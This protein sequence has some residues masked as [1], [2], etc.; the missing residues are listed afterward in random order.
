[1][2]YTLNT[3]A[4]KCT[5]FLFKNLYR[6]FSKRRL[7]Q[8]D[9]CKH[10]KSNVF[11]L[12]CILPKTTYFPSRDASFL[13]V[14]RNCELFL[15]GSVVYIDI[16]PETKVRTMLYSD[17]TVY[18]TYNYRKKYTGCPSYLFNTEISFKMFQIRN[19]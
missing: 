3:T 11:R 6:L 12:L 2:R 17:Q 13:N 9:Y 8:K 19:Y 7:L 15:S 5:F 10:T 1:M 16:T 4:T 18:T 14:M